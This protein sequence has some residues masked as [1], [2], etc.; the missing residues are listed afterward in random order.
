MRQLALLFLLLLPG[1]S[2][3]S[4][5]LLPESF[6]IAVD[7]TYIQ[8]GTHYR[9]NAQYYYEAAKNRSRVDRVNGRYNDYCG[10]VLPNDT[11][12]C[13]QLVTKG[14]RW[15]YFTGKRQCCLCC[16]SAQGCGILKRNW[17]EGAT[18]IGR[19]RLID[20]YY[21]KWEKDGHFGANTCWVTTDTNILR[22]IDDGNKHTSDFLIHTFQNKT[23][24]DSYFAVP[25]YCNGT[26]C[27]AASLCGK[28]TENSDEMS[29][30]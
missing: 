14:N 8:N 20:T 17:L 12:P 29:D 18:Y 7:E 26:H 27:P 24:D 3:I 10:S 22:R 16:T 2:H 5:P 23:F 30:F 6:Q 1:I 25:S 28:V 9:V 15:I 4:P 19:E 13:T 21:D 11:T